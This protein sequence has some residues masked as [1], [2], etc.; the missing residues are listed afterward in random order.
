MPYFGNAP[1]LYLIARF[2]AIP[3]AI[4]LLAMHG[5]YTNLPKI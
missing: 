2:Y 1:I 4:M 3:Q 5:L